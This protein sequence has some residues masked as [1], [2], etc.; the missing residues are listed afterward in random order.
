[1]WI[2]WPNGDRME[3]CSSRSPPLSISSIR[4]A[5][6]LGPSDVL[7][8]LHRTYQEGDIVDADTTLLFTVR[9]PA[10]PRAKCRWVMNAEGKVGNAFATFGDVCMNLQIGWMDPTSRPYAIRDVKEW[11]EW[12][13][14]HFPDPF[15]VLRMHPT[16][17]FL[18]PIGYWSEV[19]PNTYDNFQ[20]SQETRS[21]ILDHADRSTLSTW[22]TWLGDRYTLRFTFHPFRL[23][24]DEETSHTVWPH[25]MIYLRVTPIYRVRRGVHD[26]E[27]TVDVATIDKQDEE[28][29]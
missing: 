28:R 16:G 26:C 23:T 27:M 14:P 24:L 8:D 9:Q 7:F 29:R 5:A 13:R 1:M 17:D 18:I 3:V 6:G 21:E 4:R 2:Q 20:P 19:V 25:F 10:P 15:Q 22:F 12:S 11:V